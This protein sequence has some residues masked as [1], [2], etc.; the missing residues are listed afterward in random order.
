MTNKPKLPIYCLETFRDSYEGHHQAFAIKR[1]EDLKQN[2]SFTQFPHKHDFYDV[3]FITEG[4]GKHTIDFQTYE[5]KPY[6]IFFLT[7]GQVHSWEL[8]EDTKGF[9]IFFEAEFYGIHRSR[10]RLRDMPF[11]HVLSGDPAL[12]LSRESEEFV[13]EIIEQMYEEQANA[14]HRYAEIIRAYLELLLM[15]LSRF[16]DKQQQETSTPYHQQLI[17]RY[18]EMIDS[19]YI[20]KRMVSEY[21]DML[22]MSTKNLNAICKK[23]VNRTASDMIFNRIILEAKRLLLNAE[24]SVQQVGEMLH[25]YDSSYFVRFFRKHSGIT[26]EQFR[27]K[28][29]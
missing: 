2:F 29:C 3:L 16:Y 20:E 24:W 18:E 1:I 5:V 7:P 13:E 23:T 11:F 21:A 14:R 27:R 4:H 9:S 22:N 15:R 19:H 12:H 25:F 6:T 8:S 28:Y 17:I 10:G 26:P